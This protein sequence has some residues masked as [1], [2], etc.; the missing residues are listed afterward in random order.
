MQTACISPRLPARMQ[1][2]AKDQNRTGRHLQYLVTPLPSTNSLTVESPR[3]P[4]II[5]SNWC[6]LAYLHILVQDQPLNTTVSTLRPIPPG[7]SEYSPRPDLTESIRL[8]SETMKSMACK[9]NDGAGDAY[10]SNGLHQ[11]ALGQTF[12]QLNG[13]LRTIRN[14]PLPL[15]LLNIAYHPLLHVQLQSEPVIQEFIPEGI[16]PVALLILSSSMGKPFAIQ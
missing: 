11:P 2:G 4:N 7:W 5:R 15:I 9:V 14:H 1:L 3:L 8:V 6:R 13:S 10:Q 12:N 16:V